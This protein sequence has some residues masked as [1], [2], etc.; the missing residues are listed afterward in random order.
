MKNQIY[1]HMVAQQARHEP[2]KTREIAN[3]FNLDVYQARYYLLH[4]CK[5]GRVIKSGTSRGAPVYWSLSPP[6]K[7]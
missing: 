3:E 6:S 7:Q 2:W 4:L 1:L 5:E